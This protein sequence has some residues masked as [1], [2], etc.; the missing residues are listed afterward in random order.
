MIS[1]RRCPEIIWRVSWTMIAIR[2]VVVA[3]DVHLFQI[4]FISVCDRLRCKTSSIIRLW[5]LNNGLFLYEVCVLRLMLL[6]CVYLML[7]LRAFAN[8]ADAAVNLWSMLFPT[9]LFLSGYRDELLRKL[10]TWLHK[11]PALGISPYLL[12]R[13]RYLGFIFDGQGPA[14]IQYSS[15]S[16][17]IS[18]HHLAVFYLA[19]LSD[20]QCGLCIQD[21]FQLS[22]SLAFQ[23]ST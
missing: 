9:S 13:R 16:T 14:S 2:S 7:R 20:D 19:K 4:V 15:T 11:S 8:N 5:K 10:S 1:A 23:V 21:I 12:M 22:G 18:S 3:V 6:F 17:L